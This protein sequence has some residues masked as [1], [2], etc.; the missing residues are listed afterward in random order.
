MVGSHHNMESCREGL[1]CWEGGE[2][3]HSPALG[4]HKPCLSCSCGVVC[5]SHQKSNQYTECLRNV[6]RALPAGSAYLWG[7]RWQQ[8]LPHSTLPSSMLTL[9]QETLSQSK[10]CA[11]PL[12]WRK[13]LLSPL[14][15]EASLTSCLDSRAFQRQVLEFSKSSVRR[16]RP[17]TF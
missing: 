1:Q 13:K 5:V 8:P 11:L 16:N 2:P 12:S 6:V 7:G 14:S 17:K 3:L 10:T 4:S 15:A 9:A